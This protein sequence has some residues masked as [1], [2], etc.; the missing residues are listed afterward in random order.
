MAGVSYPAALAGECEP[1]ERGGGP[2]ADSTLAR[3]RWARG[4]DSQTVTWER[5]DTTMV[6]RTALS[7][8]DHGERWQGSPASGYR[9]IPARPGSKRHRMS[10]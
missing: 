8:L 3:C 5:L 2:D 6:H 1:I 7:S 9:Q 4:T 10:K